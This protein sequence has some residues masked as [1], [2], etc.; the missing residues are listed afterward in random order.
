M[1]DKNGP[2]VLFINAG[3]EPAG[4]MM[5]EVKVVHRDSPP[6]F[7]LKLGAY[8]RKHGID[9]DVIDTHLEE[10]YGGVIT[11]KL[12]EK[13]YTIVGF[14]VY[15]GL[16]LRNS[17]EL[18]NLCREV[19]PSTPIIWGGPVPS[20][21][22]EQ[23]LTTYQPDYVARFEGEETLLELV[24]AI[25]AGKEVKGIGGLSFMADGKVYHGPPRLLA[26]DGLNKYPIPDWTLLGSNVNRKQI[27]YVVYIRTSQG[28]PHNC[29]FCY[30][31]SS[32]HPDSIKWRP[33]SVEHVLEEV[34]FLHKHYGIEVF[35][36]GDDNFLSHK[37]RALEIFE[38]FRK[39]GLYIEELVGHMAHFDDDTIEAMEGLVAQA[40][41]NCE[42]ASP[43]LLKIMNKKTDL[44]KVPGRIKK[45][46]DHG[47][48]TN[49]AFIVGVPEETEDDLRNI[50]ELMYK[51]R[52]VHPYI[53]GISSF[54]M[55][56]PGTPMFD[57]LGKFYGCEIPGDIR[58]YEN[59]EELPFDDGAYERIKLFHPG[60]SRERFTLL[61][62]FQIIFRDL[63]R[64]NNLSEKSKRLLSED[65]L[66][67]KLFDG[68]ENIRRPLA[69]YRPYILDQL[70]SG[71]KIDLKRN[72]HI[73]A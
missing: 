58:I 44:D 32:D 30:H 21:M 57:Y 73:H 46:F 7:A 1:P 62:N 11:R 15:I 72:L 8:L 61:T 27:P 20:S 31:Q 34:D 6:Y 49:S 68:Y 42:S 36:I 47:I 16:F 56:I 60:M 39:R 40:G 37:R 5:H 4:R 64:Y 12:K 26:K 18:T 35:S 51:L 22:P 69:P 29:S 2:S 70:L 14:T 19:S 65:S 50:V 71:Q 10:D 23:V 48:T 55:P 38:G 41:F 67:R 52:D 28:C 54:Y 24:K 17:G 3:H 63:F 25:D 66:L 33:R 53:R 13:K 43:H 45:L 59:Y 9:V